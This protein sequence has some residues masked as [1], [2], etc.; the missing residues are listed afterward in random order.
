MGYLRICS[1]A[2]SSEAQI[3]ASPRIPKSSF[4]SSIVSS[5]KENLANSTRHRSPYG[6]LSVSLSCASSDTKV[7]S[8]G[9]ASAKEKGFSANLL[10][11][12]R[13]TSIRVCL[14]VRCSSSPSRPDW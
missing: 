3:K 8:S 7:S 11:T 4:C 6:P 10:K 13:F 14:E 2:V 12:V 9:F 1:P 5:E